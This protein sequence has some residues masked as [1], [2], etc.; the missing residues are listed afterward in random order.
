MKLEDLTFNSKLEYIIKN[1]SLAVFKLSNSQLWL[2]QKAPRLD[3]NLGPPC[4]GATAL[5]SPP[6][7]CL[8]VCFCVS[9]ITVCLSRV[10]FT[11]RPVASGVGS[12][13]PTTL[14]W[15]SGMDGLEQ[16]YR[17]PRT[18][19]KHALDFA[20][21][22][23]ICTWNR[24]FSLKA[25]SRLKPTLSLVVFKRHC[26][27]KWVTKCKIANVQKGGFG[28]S[29]WKTTFST[30]FRDYEWLDSRNDLTACLFQVRSLKQASPL[31]SSDPRSVVLSCKVPQAVSWFLRGSFPHWPY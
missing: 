16:K 9:F 25:L 21:K 14:I 2:T 27:E 24:I 1:T 18:F 19:L 3:S 23:L 11:S 28:K 17:E 4:C 13:T 26:S 22:Q 30:E 10:S 31:V 7:C 20:S 12:S 15:I 5:T 8:C 6:L 29:E